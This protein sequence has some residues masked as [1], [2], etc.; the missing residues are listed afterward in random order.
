L[1]RSTCKRLS[2]RLGKLTL[3]K[4]SRYGKSLR[5]GMRLLHQMLQKIAVWLILDQTTADYSKTSLQCP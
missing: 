3:D 4:R 1:Q 2:S 5:L